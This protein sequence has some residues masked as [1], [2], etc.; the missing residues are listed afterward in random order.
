MS[1]KQQ[2][3]VTPEEQKRQRDSF[4]TKLAEVVKRNYKEEQKTSDKK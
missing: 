1:K 2:T 3:P 4:L